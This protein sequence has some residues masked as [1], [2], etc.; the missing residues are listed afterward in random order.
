MAS[1]AGEVNNYDLK[2]GRRD[3]LLLQ[4]KGTSTGSTGSLGAALTWQDDPGITIVKQA[5][6]GVYNVTFPKGVDASGSIWV[7]VISAAGTV[8]GAFVTAADFNAGTASFTTVDAA[9]AATNPIAGES[10]T[11]SILIPMRKDF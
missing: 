8:R 7:D 6:N 10:V 1:V 2:S 5:G 3:R 4:A 11:V 9:G